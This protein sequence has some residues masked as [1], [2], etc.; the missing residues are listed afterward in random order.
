ML[1]VGR[2]EVDDPVD[3]LGRVEGVDGGE[4][5]VAG[6][7]RRERRAHGLLVAHLADQDHVGVLAQDAAHRPREAVRVGADLALVDDRAFVFVQVLDRV[8]ERDD[9]VRAGA[10]DV[11]DHRRQR[12]ALARAGGAGDEDDPALLLGQV[13]DHFGQAEILDRADLEGDRAADDRGR[14][15]LFEGVDAEARDAR[16]RVGE[17][18]LAFLFEFGLRAHLGDVV[19]G[20]LGFLA[21]Q[22]L[23]PLQG[24]ELA[25]QANRRRRGHLDVQI[26]AA[27]L[28]ERAQS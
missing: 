20:L 3:R 19:E 12:R 8:L 10:V 24:D 2:E 14:A 25:V 28:D 21:A 22:R 13:G 9:V 16:D 26:G 5:E 11:V 18:G 4:H 27:P 23:L 7:R 17:V 15:A 1:Q 6:L